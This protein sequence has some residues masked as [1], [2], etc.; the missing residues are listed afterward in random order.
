[1]QLERGRCPRASLTLGGR[2]AAYDDDDNDNE[3][4]ENVED[5]FRDDD[6]N[7]NGLEIAALIR[8]RRTNEIIRK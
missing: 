4:V 5:D 3:D 2:G 1:M 7:G 8:I 6:E